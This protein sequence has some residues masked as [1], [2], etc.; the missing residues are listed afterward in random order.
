[1][2][3]R[4][5][6]G[7]HVGILGKFAVAAALLSLVGLTVTPVGA[8][9]SSAH[10]ST[11][12]VIYVIGY[13]Q[14]NPFWVL[15][16]V[17]AAQA[18]KALGVTVRYEAPTTASDAGMIAL[19]DAALATHPYGIAIDYTDHAMQASVLAALKEG[20]KVVLY[21]NNRFEPQSGG[22]TKNSA[23]TQLAYV[24]QTESHSGAVLGAAF[25]PFLPKTGNVLIINPYAGAYVLTLR[26]NGLTSV[27]HPAGHTTS[28]LVVNGDSSEG[29]IEAVISAY[30]KAHTSVVG[31][32]ALGDPAGNPAARAIAAAGLKIPVC[33]FDMETETYQ[34]MKSGG[35]LKA[36]LDQQPYLQAYYAVQDLAFQMRDGFQPVS[37]NTGTLVVTKAN[38]AALTLL[39]NSGKD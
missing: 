28:T 10:A 35:P 11:S 1:M 25:L 6:R 8:M 3:Y 15:E 5:W 24:G 26:A 27:L 4:N 32:A 7:K 18:G 37:V 22:A 12:K 39:I 20:V 19:I 29:T 33:T 9:A 14:A 16:G 23:I 21:N 31:V 17:G 34:L 36:A 30:L 2:Q 38:L 13:E